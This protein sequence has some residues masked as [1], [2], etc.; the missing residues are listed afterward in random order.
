MESG[1]KVGT[2]VEPMK[3]FVVVGESA[4][5]SVDVSTLRAGQPTV[6]LIVNA[7]HWSRPVARF[8]KTLDQEL[9]RGIDGAPEAAAVAVWFTSDVEKSK[10]YLPVAQNSI[11]FEKTWLAVFEGDQ[12]GPP[13][14]AINDQAHLTAVVV[15]GDKVVAS[16][17]YISLNETDVPKVIKTLKKQ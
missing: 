8:L 9:S 16:L 14:W 1:P 3:A 6:Y 2:K 10:T 17:G 15:Q 7:E 5:Q 12:F 11:Q 4:G 13:A